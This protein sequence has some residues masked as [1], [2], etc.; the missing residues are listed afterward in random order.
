MTGQGNGRRL[1]WRCPQETAMS[2]EL[3]D[4]LFERLGP[5][6]LRVLAYISVTLIAVPL[7]M[8]ALVPFF[9]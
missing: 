2:D 7:G 8:I 5:I 4:P 3:N 1:R 9:G 6:V